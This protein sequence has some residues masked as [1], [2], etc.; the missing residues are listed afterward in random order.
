MKK[1]LLLSSAIAMLMVCGLQVKA[2]PAGD[3][4]RPAGRIQ[5]ANGH[6]KGLQ[7][8]PAKSNVAAM[9]S[10]MK[11][12]AK[13]A[14]NGQ[15]VLVSEDFSKFTAG[16]EAQPDTAITNAL[17]DAYIVGDVTIPDEY[18]SQVGWTGSQVYQAGG[19]LCLRALDSQYPAYVNTPIGDYSGDITVSFRVK[20]IDFTYQNNTSTTG[21][22]IYVNIAKGASSKVSEAETEN[23]DDNE[24]RLYPGKGWTEITYTCRNHSAD[25]DG[26]VQI[27]CTGSVLIDDFK[28]TAGYGFLA[29]PH[30]LRTY[31]FTEDGFKVDFEKTRRASNYRFYLF[32]RVLTSDGD[33]SY[34]E[35]FENVSQKGRARLDN[36]FS[37]SAN[38]RVKSGEGNGSS[39]AL[40]L[41]NGDSLTTPRQWR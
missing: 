19:M 31:G 3:A 27:S 7:Q 26:L 41:N 12:V 10:P 36:G 8:F 16:S 20:A 25:L 9:K 22:T 39:A 15:D 18:T 14:M 30:V 32:R 35:D 5:L 38:V 33:L 37:A 23:G 34:S 6:A 4:T 13:R 21:S 2:A 17:A 28:V 24:F 29:G 1:N 11:A 40:V